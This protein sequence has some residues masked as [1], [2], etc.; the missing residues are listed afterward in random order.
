MPVYQLTDKLVFPPAALAEKDGLLAIGGDLSPARLL[1]AYSNGIFPWF[2]EGDP[3]LWWSPSPR[4]VIFPDEFKVPKRLSRLIRQKEYSVTLDQAFHQVITACATVAAR[5]EK[6]TWITRDMVAAYSLLHEMGYAHSVECWQ[7]G[8]L[9][10][11]LYGISLGGVFFGESMFS[12]QPNSSKIALVFLLQ[13]LL[14]WDFDLIDCQM[15]TVHLMQFGAREI[16]GAEFQK[17]LAESVSRP[18]QRGKWQLR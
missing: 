2:S 5:Q 12:R 11:G 4:L 13:K 9:A 16:S 14:E 18:T 6:G 1:L 8:E 7:D 17:L 15:K 10:G 3:L